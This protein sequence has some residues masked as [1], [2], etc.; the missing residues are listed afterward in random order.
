MHL[1][2]SSVPEASE[3]PAPVLLPSHAPNLPSSPIIDGKAV[4]VVSSST[5][6]RIDPSTGGARREQ[7]TPRLLMGGE[8]L[9]AN[10]TRL[11][12]ADR[13]RLVSVDKNGLLPSIVLVHGFLMPPCVAA[14]E[15]TFYVK[16]FN[17]PGIMAV[18]LPDYS[19]H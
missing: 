19:A 13:D 15:K 16:L 17:E 11:C 7:L 10:A 14:D 6:Y 18:P 4:F 8:T 12:V 3:Y 5:V 1:R 9:V 2:A